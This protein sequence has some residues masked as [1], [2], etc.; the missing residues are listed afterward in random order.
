MEWQGALSGT[1]EQEGGGGEGEKNT[2]CRELVRVSL[3]KFPEKYEQLPRR[4]R[5]KSGVDAAAE[6]R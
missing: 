1:G 2:G 4:K 3:L 5:G 6:W